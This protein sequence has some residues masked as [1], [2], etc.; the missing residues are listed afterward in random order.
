M[1]AVKRPV[2]IVETGE[3][4]DSLLACAIEIGGH[5][6]SISKVLGGKQ[7]K[8]LGY[9]FVRIKEVTNGGNRAISTST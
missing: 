7:H 8:H 6:S 5:S 1:A 3:E 2:R 9:T 4:F